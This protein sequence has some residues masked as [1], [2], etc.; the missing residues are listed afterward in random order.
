MALLGGSPAIDA[1]DDSV[2]GAPL[3]LTTDQRGP[4]FA[5]KSGS[6]VD[7]GAFEVSQPDPGGPTITNA[8]YDSDNGILTIRGPGFGTQLHLEANGLIVAP[9]L[10]IKIKGGGTKL[11]IVGSPSDLNLRGGPNRVVIIDG[12]LRSNIFVLTL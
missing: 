5:R 1:G 11:K 12:G 9:P 3:F 7:I 8:G 10:H 6:H 2:L 4:G